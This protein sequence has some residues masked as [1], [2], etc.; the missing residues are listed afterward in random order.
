MDEIP[1]F[2]KDKP[3]A[4]LSLADR[5]EIYQDLIAEFCRTGAVGD[6]EL[7]NKCAIEWI[8][9]YADNLPLLDKNLIAEYLS[10]K[11][12]GAE[13]RKAEILAKIQQS[14]EKLGPNPVSF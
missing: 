8:E 7:T 4:E 14:L 6:L 10:L 5:N 12:S 2:E 9:K 11:A 3:D 1:K 13:N